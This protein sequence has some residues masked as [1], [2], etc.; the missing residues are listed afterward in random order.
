MNDLWARQRL[1][2]SKPAET[3][4]VINTQHGLTVLEK[5]QRRHVRTS[6]VTV[7]CHGPIDTASRGRSCYHSELCRHACVWRQNELLSVF[8]LIH[9][10]SSE[11][12][13]VA[14][15]KYIKMKTGT[16]QALWISFMVVFQQPKTGAHLKNV[17]NF[18]DLVV[19]AVFLL[20]YCFY[21]FSAIS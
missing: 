14:H 13:V 7:I 10:R 17:D 8:M 1:F 12:V 3:S 19:H 4:W 2:D 5:S 21:N 9:T 18:S 6:Y 20:L 16:R 15:A 11:K